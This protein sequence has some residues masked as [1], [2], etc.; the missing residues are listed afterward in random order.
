MSLYGNYVEHLSLVSH[1]ICSMTDNYFSYTNTFSKI[2]KSLFLVLKITY[3]PACAPVYWIQ[4]GCSLTLTLIHMWNGKMWLAIRFWNT[5]LYQLAPVYQLAPLSPINDFKMAGFPKLE[6]TNNNSS[7]TVV[8]KCN[9]LPIGV[10]VV[11]YM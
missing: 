1:Q 10:L 2:H 7:I 8:R 11:M 5:K 4:Y 6:K 9:S 3:H